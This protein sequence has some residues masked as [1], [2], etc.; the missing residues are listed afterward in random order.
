MVDT[1][2]SGASGG[3]PVEVRVLFSVPRFLSRIKRAFFLHGIEII[4]LKI[5]IIFKKAFYFVLNALMGV[6]V[7]MKAVLLHEKGYRYTKD[8]GDTLT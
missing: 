2:A 3:N 1:L 7:G 6:V 4:K 5:D 8:S